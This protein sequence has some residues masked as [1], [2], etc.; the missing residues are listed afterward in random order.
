MSNL[1]TLSLS[2][3]LVFFLSTLNYKD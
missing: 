1:V 3:E 2:I